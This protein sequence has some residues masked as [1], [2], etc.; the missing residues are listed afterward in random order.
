MTC[1]AEGDE[2]QSSMKI[3]FFKYFVLTSTLSLFYLR[4]RSVVSPFLIMS[5]KWVLQGI[6]IGITRDLEINQK[7]Y[8]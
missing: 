4:Y 7:D 5:K 6:C 8:L 2:L 3:L 1:S